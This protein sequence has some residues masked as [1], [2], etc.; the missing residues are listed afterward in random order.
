MIKLFKNYLSS[1]SASEFNDRVHHFRSLNFRKMSYEE[2]VTAINDVLKGSS[3]SHVLLGMTSIFPRKTTFFRVRVPNCSGS[4]LPMDCALI[5]ADAWE[6]PAEFAKQSRINRSQEPLLYTAI[7]SIATA[8]DEVRL[9]EGQYAAVFVY[10]AK[11]KIKLNMIGARYNLTGLTE[12]E[13]LKA[14]LITDFLYDRFTRDAGPE[15]QHIYRISEIIAKHYFDLPPKVAQ[16][17]WGFPSVVGKPNLNACFRPEI[18]RDCLALRGA[19][20]GNRAGDNF[21]IKMV[22]ALSD[23]HFQY[24]GLGSEIQKKLFPEVI[25]GPNP[26]SES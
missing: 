24:H 18:A 10:L 6:P 9:K 2:T 17:A 4:N 13:R 3:N 16:D 15:N 12:D 8:M 25:I 11:R 20:I 1:F 23:G 19:F 21:R 26:P 22:A 7:N 5:E 14:D